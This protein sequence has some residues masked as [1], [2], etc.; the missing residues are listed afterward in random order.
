MI[1]GVLGSPRAPPR[2]QKGTGFRGSFWPMVHGK[3]L[4][5][6][7]NYDFQWTIV[8]KQPSLTFFFNRSLNPKKYIFN[9]TCGP[10]GQQ[11]GSKRRVLDMSS[12]FKNDKKRWTIGAKTKLSLFFPS[13]FC[14]RFRLEAFL[15][16]GKKRWEVFKKTPPKRAQKSIF[17]KLGEWP[18]FGG[19]DF[20]WSRVP[21]GTQKW[22]KMKPRKLGE[23]P[24]L[25]SQGHSPNSQKIKSS[26]T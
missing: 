4:I 10:N 3:P 5:F 25:S 22:P 12:F 24:G 1:W 15:K 9:E 23:W 20:G 7:E 2:P 13:L 16:N 26:L 8:K 17:R 18:F 19:I 11:Q 14:S 6:H 21:F